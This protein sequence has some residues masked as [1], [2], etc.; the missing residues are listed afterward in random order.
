MKST[1]TADREMTDFSRPSPNAPASHLPKNTV[2]LINDN[3][4]AYKVDFKDLT[5]KVSIEGVL[6]ETDKYMETVSGLLAKYHE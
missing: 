4:T 3:P 1:S 5:G 6:V 2:L